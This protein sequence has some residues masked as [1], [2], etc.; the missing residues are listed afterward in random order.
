[1]AFVSPFLFAMDSVGTASG[2]NQQLHPNGIGNL[3]V[4]P[5]AEPDVHDDKQPFRNLHLHSHRHSHRPAARGRD[6]GIV[7]L[8]GGLLG[9][10]S[11]IETICLLLLFLSFERS[12][13]RFD[14]FHPATPAIVG[15]VATVVLRA[16][17]PCT[18]PG[19]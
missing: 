8:V 1:M 4:E 10:T 11:P 14:L 2:A 15:G 16:I 3:D 18:R 6:P 9:V 13:Y 19:R 12:V 7:H 5:D 17:C